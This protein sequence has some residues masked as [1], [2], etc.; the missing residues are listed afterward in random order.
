MI[1]INSSRNKTLFY[2]TVTDK[3]YIMNLW[4]R[5]LWVDSRELETH[6]SNTIIMQIII[7]RPI[8]PASARVHKIL[9]PTRARR[10]MAR[11]PEVRLPSLLESI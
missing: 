6:I 3:W 7:N 10:G 11:R 4:S 9:G 2:Q 8:R 5:I 1:T